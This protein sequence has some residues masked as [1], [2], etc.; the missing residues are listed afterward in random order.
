MAM[1]MVNNLLIK[2]HEECLFIKGKLDRPALV[3]T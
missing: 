3:P 1:I 2:M